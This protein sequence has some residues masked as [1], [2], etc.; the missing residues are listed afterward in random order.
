MRRVSSTARIYN[1]RWIPCCC[2]EQP[3]VPVPTASIPSFRIGFL[4]ETG[5]H[6]YIYMWLSSPGVRL[7]FLFSPFSLS[8]WS[9]PCLSLCFVSPPRCPYAGIFLSFVLLQSWRSNR[10]ETA[11]T[12][13]RERFTQLAKLSIDRSADRWNSQPTYFFNFS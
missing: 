8:F 6:I 9:L 10:A 13:T 5:T 3:R 12:Q 7:S 2:L 4:A 1:T 11:M